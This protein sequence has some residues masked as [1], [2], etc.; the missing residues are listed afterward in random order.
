MNTVK[1][2]EIDNLQNTI[3][4]KSGEICSGER[5]LFLLKE[6]PRGRKPTF[7][8]EDNR[9]VVIDISK[10]NIEEIMYC[11][12]CGFQSTDLDANC[13][14]HGR[15]IVMFGYRIKGKQHN[16]YSDK[17]WASLNHDFKKNFI[18]LDRFKTIN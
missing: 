13:P 4:T 8:T 16:I 18:Y 3:F 11:D 7:Y 10:D 9:K 14:N 17:Q 5:I 12:S 6:N 15:Y 2:S 1:L